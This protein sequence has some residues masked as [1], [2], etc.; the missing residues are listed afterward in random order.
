MNSLKVFT[1][2]MRVYAQRLSALPRP[3]HSTGKRDRLRYFTLTVTSE[4]V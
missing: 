2:R 1:P 3:T 4:S